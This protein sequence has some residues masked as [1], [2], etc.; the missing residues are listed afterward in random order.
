MKVA[1]KILPV[2]KEVTAIFNTTIPTKNWLNYGKIIK[3][4]SVH[5]N[6]DNFVGTTWDCVVFIPTQVRS[7]SL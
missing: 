3:S 4:F 7:Y 2:H 1:N 5:D 6:F